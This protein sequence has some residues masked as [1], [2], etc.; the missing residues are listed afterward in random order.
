M[1]LTPNTP[2]PRLTL[3]GL[4]HDVYDTASLAGQRHMIAFF[5]FASCPFCHM[6]VRELVTRHEAL[7]GMPIVAIFDSTIENLREHA[8]GHQAPFPILAD[9]T[10]QAYA[11]YAI[12]RSVAGLLKGLVTRMPTLLKGMSAGFVPLSPKGSL[13]TMPA[14]F[15]VD[16]AGLIQVAYYGADEGDHMPIE[17]LRAFA[18][19]RPGRDQEAS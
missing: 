6:R 10:G 3:P 5:R 11:T 4:T 17:R 13:T 2:A 19:E 1:R 18:L 7:E 8:S 12:E 9:A 14:E 15:L 16:E